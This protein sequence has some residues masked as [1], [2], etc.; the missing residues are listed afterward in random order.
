MVQKI[1]APIKHQYEW[2]REIREKL[3]A[4]LRDKV[5]SKWQRV[6]VK[7]EKVR[8]SDKL[9]AELLVDLGVLY[10]AGGMMK[11]KRPTP[12]YVS[13]WLRENLDVRND[14]VYGGLS[15]GVVEQAQKMKSLAYERMT[16]YM[17]YLGSQEAR[18][19][20][21]DVNID[22]EVGLYIDRVRRE[23]R[24]SVGDIRGLDNQVKWDEYTSQLIDSIKQQVAGA[25]V[26]EVERFKTRGVE[27]LEGSN[28]QDM[29]NWFGVRYAGA[30]VERRVDIRVESEGKKAQVDAMGWFLPESGFQY[31]VW[32]TKKDSKVRPDHARLEGRIIN[33]NDPPVVDLR[34]GRRRHPGED[35]NCYSKDTEVYTKDGFKLIKDVAIGEMILTLNPITQGVEWGKCISKVE[36]HC[37]KIAHIQGHMF[38]LKVDPDHTFF[39]Y[40]DVEHGKNQ[41]KMYGTKIWYTR[42]PQ[43]RVGV[44]SLSKTCNFYRSSKWVGEDKG[45]IRIGELEI[46][47]EDYC[48]LMGYY[49]SEGNID[50][51]EDRNGIKISQIKYLDKMF[52]DLAFFNPRKGE[53]A[54]WIFNTELN[55]YLGKFGYAIDK[56]VPDEIKKLDKRYI[57]IFLDAYAL[58]DGT[59]AK[60]TKF[61]QEKGLMTYNQY[62]T[63]SRK[64][65]HD[66][67]ECVIKAGMGVSIYFTAQKGKKIA[68]KNGTY[69]INTNIYW[70]QELKNQYNSAYSMKKEIVEYK[71]S[72]YDIEVDRNHTLLIKSG[73]CIHWN[74]N[75]RCTAAPL[76]D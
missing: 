25:G 36:K 34:S 17:Q 69:R 6:T 39:V 62:H 70:I 8:R 57:R 46:P 44:E 51:R 59:P 40:K 45:I 26:F 22:R 66:L 52:E 71:D 4:A 55:K 2:T 30:V 65:A 27:L 3:K 50:K 9:S 61:N 7:G 47:T 33:W 67:A 42:E 41:H 37:D 15:R 48:K 12:A 32:T 56:Y 64:M 63:S 21:E 60:K 14:V 49:L 29:E 16:D 72:V 53:E 31:Y 19:V 35:Y 1:Y 28:T 5:W 23:I 73:K 54:I 75:C 76:K 20:V 38:D 74:G 58:G 13:L 24:D 68:F 10:W 18:K 11:V 43:F